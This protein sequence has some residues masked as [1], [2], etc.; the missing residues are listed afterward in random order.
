VDDE[1]RIASIDLHTNVEKISSAIYVIELI[2]DQSLG[3]AQVDESDESC[4][5]DDEKKRDGLKFVQHND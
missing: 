3:A 2:E 4:D 5:E 1:F